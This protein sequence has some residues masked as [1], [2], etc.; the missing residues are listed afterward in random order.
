M[1]VTGTAAPFG[2]PDW[3]DSFWKGLQKFSRNW[4][5]S[6]QRWKTFCLYGKKICKPSLH[7]SWINF[8]KVFR[9]PYKG[10]HFTESSTL[11]NSVNLLTQDRVD[12]VWSHW[13]RERHHTNSSQPLD[14]MLPNPNL[15]GRH[16]RPSEPRREKQEQK[17]KLCYKSLGSYRNT[18]VFFLYG[19]N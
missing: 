1:A 11:Q 15:M 10:S 6:S 19:K 3:I 4:S 5:M 16:L 9:H 13:R 12:V 8:I 17:P 14:Q 7:L 18:I 2:I